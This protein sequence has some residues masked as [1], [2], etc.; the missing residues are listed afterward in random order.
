MNCVSKYD[1]LAWLEEHGTFISPIETTP[2]GKYW[3]AWEAY[4]GLGLTTEASNVESL[5]D[6]MYLDI[7]EGLFAEC[8]G[9]S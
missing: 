4:N 2:N 8:N 3:I 7:K 9:S 5:Y 1:S 6:N